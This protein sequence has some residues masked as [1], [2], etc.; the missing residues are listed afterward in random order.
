MKKALF[1]AKIMLIACLLAAAAC[2]NAPTPTA[3]TPTASPQGGLPSGDPA[4]EFAKAEQA[5]AKG[6][7][8]QA[9]DSYQLVFKGTNDAALRHK[10]FFRL[11]ESLTS[12]FRYGEA[13][14]LL[15]DTPLPGEAGERA[16]VLLL[17]AGLL[18]SFL[19][20]YEYLLDRNE[21]EESGNAFHLTRE[22]V[23]AEIGNDWLE[24]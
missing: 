22:Q 10:S 12:L 19:R 14:Q 16:R 20:Q 8:Q 9:Y 5:F 13:A 15:M 17:K 21:N 3:Q 1:P 23:E 24:A 18:Q 2:V 6:A 4:A 7:F 11:C